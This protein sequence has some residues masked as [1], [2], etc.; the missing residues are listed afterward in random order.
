MSSDAD[1][2]FSL[3]PPLRGAIISFCCLGFAYLINN[4]A[5]R[6]LDSSAEKNLLAVRTVRAG[7]IRNALSI[8]AALALALAWNSPQPVFIATLI[9]LTGGFLYSQRPRLKAFPVAGTLTNVAIFAPLLAMG[10]NRPRMPEGLWILTAI[11]SGLIV[12]NQLIHEGADEDDDRRGGARTTFVRFGH[13]ATLW[14]GA[15]AALG[16][17]LAA[18]RW[19]WLLAGGI[20]AVSGAW[21][22]WRFHRLRGDAGGLGRLRLQQRKWSL[23][24]GA[25]SF[26]C[27][28]AHSAGNPVLTPLRQVPLPNI[29]AHLDILTAKPV[30]YP[31]HY[32]GVLTTIAGT[33]ILCVLFAAA[34]WLL[35]PWFVLT[36]LAVAISCAA[37]GGSAWALSIIGR[38]GNFFSCSLPLASGVTLFLALAALA[39]FTRRPLAHSAS[40][41]PPQTARWL[42]W[43]CAA[44]WLVKNFL[45]LGGRILDSGYVPPLDAAFWWR[46]DTLHSYPEIWGNDDFGIYGPVMSYVTFPFMPLAPWLSQ[47]LWGD[48]AWTT[49]EMPNLHLLTAG[50]RASVAALDLAIMAALARAAGPAW[51][52]A[53]LLWNLNPIALHSTALAPNEL[54]QLPFLLWGL[55]LL[56]ERPALSG[57]LLMGAVLVKPTPAPLL[58]FWGWHGSWKHRFLFTGGAVL[59]CAVFIG[60]WLAQ[61]S[62]TPG[63]RGFDALLWRAFESEG[64]NVWLIPAEIVGPEAV[65]VMR[66]LIL[67]GIP[68]A[69]TASIFGWWKKRPFALHSD[70]ALLLAA[71]GLVTANIH[72]GY[73]IPPLLVLW[74]AARPAS[75]PADAGSG[76]AGEHILPPEKADE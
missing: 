36:P 32:G 63:F 23:A 6:T 2:D 65:R 67:L 43:A 42:A 38:E 37:A 27:M 22:P 8:M 1:P 50:S 40:A 64:C 26:L 58:P 24:A 4:W 60:A 39:A 69:V 5:D 55:L 52:A 71:P 10:L 47:L 9:S 15:A 75:P 35:R 7:A 68:L 66:G 53:L 12:Q 57:V 3:W 76:Q 62:R 73:L 61:M 41:P 28:Q 25:A 48:G 56:R 44:A 20:A 54:W 30:M 31:V 45:A 51:P 46:G 11:F 70:S 29:A 13:T 19:N 72:P 74:I 49:A 17:A 21:I 14:L 16:S 18:A 34:A 33:V 59:S